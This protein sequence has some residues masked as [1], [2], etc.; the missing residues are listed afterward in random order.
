M[1]RMKDKKDG[2]EEGGK[3]EQRE[4]KGGGGRG[5]KGKRKEKMMKKVGGGAALCGQ[6]LAGYHVYFASSITAGWCYLF[7]FY[8]EE[9]E[10]REAK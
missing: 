4:E 5:A 7:H 9:S 1:Y 3:G 8:R 10:G 2:E 6:A